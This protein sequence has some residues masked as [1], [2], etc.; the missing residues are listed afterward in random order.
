MNKKDVLTAIK[1]LSEKGILSKNEVLS[2]FEEGKS[3]ENHR[4]GFTLGISSVLYLIGALIV[5]VGIA[6]LIGQNWESLNPVTRI[7]STLGF[8]FLSYLLGIVFNK[9]EKYGAASYAFHLIAGLAFPIGL[10]VVFDLFKLNINDLGIQSFIAWVLLLFYIGAFLVYRKTIFTLFVIVYAT[11][12]FVYFTNYLIGAN[13]L[14][15]ENKF[16]EYRYLV[17]G[18]SYGLLGYYLKS[19]SQYPLTES[20]YFFGTVFALGAMLVLGGWKPEQSYIWEVLYP[21]IVFGVLFLSTHLKSK[22][23]LVLGTIFL[24]LYILKITGEYFSG[25]LG[26]PLSLMICGLALIAIGYYAFSLNKKFLSES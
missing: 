9:E 21:G 12:F 19:T 17:I 7:L 23:M 2:A 14:F 20:L 13:P 22:S 5:F 16:Y 18:L 8:A 15:F 26:W 24:M 4:S 11:L 6:V 25:T 3:L 1:E 10:A